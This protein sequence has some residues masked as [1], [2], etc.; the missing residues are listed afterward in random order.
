MLPFI[1]YHA[2]SAS[3]GGWWRGISRPMKSIASTTLRTLAGITVLV[4]IVSI[5]YTLSEY[6]FNRKGVKYFVSYQFG[7]TTGVVTSFESVTCPGPI[8]THRDM[9]DVSDILSRKHSVPPRSVVILNWRR[10]E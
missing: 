6:T 3:S 8:K 7:G 9:L 4:T 1:K 2:N 5:A 10:F